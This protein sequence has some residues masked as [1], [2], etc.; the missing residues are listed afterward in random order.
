[1]PEP[2]GFKRGQGVMVT[3]DRKKRLEKAIGKIADGAG[4]LK[5]YPEISFYIWIAYSISRT[6]AQS[7]IIV[8]SQG[9]VLDCIEHLLDDVAHLYKDDKMGKDEI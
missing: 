4:I 5:D 6:E 7:F 9:E 3:Y 2:K 1:L 8:S